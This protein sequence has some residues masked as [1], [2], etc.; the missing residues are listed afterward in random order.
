MAG[1][2]A[3]LLRGQEVR[4]SLGARSIHG[5]VFCVDRDNDAIVIG[6]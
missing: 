4:L 3:V 2:A 5:T 6:T 1:E